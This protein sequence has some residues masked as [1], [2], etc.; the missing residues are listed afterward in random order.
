MLQII[1]CIFIMDVNKENVVIMNVSILPAP[2]RQL[3]MPLSKN[4]DVSTAMKYQLG[5]NSADKK[6]KV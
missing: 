2:P 5:C 3:C 1:K 6:V 4:Y